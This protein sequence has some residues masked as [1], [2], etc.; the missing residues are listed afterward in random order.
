MTHCFK[1][2]GLNIVLDVYSG[3]VHLVDEP[4][5]DIIGMYETTEKGEIRKRILEKYGKTGEAT[6][7]T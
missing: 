6:A 7:I 3:S 5:Y 4:T 1:S 2:G